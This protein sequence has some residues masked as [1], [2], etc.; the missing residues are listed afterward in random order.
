MRLTFLGTGG[1]QQVPVFGC[2]C[3][4]CRRAEQLPL[5]RRGPCSALIQCGGESTLLDAGQCHLEQRFRPGELRR[6]LLTHYHMDHVQ[7]LF[8]LRWG[9]GAAIPVYGPPD[10]AGCDDLFKHPGLLAFQPPVTPFAAMAFGALSVTPIPLI[11]SKLTYGYLFEYLGRRLAWLCDT[12]GL[13]AQSLQFLRAQPLTHLV[14]DC[15][16][17]P[18][19]PAPRNHN[20]VTQALAIRQALAPAQCWLT[21]LSHEM[22]NWLIDNALPP[23]VAA[24]YDGQILAL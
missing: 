18:T 5:Y 3:P 21:H 22:D 11:H 9:V 17:P 24:A 16:H 2:D 4:S 1:A 13:P 6:I 23:G 15:S 19:Q 7:G 8:P 14:L 10:D 12:A 20:D